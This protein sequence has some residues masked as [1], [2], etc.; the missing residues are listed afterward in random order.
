MEQ[1]RIDQALNTEKISNIRVVQPATLP[2]R[3]SGAGLVILLGLALVL[4][5]LCALGAA[6]ALEYFDDSIDT[7]QRA[8]AQL[9]LPVLAAL[10]ETGDPARVTAPG[11]RTNGA[12]V[13]YSELVGLRDQLWMWSA[14]RRRAF[15]AP[16]ERPSGR[17]PVGFLRLKHGQAPSAP[18]VIALTGCQ[19]GSGVSTLAGH[20]SVLLAQ[21]RHGK[22]LLV[23][24]GDGPGVTQNGAA[25]DSI[26][27]LGAGD[28]ADFEFV[29]V[30]LPAVPDTRATA[31]AAALCDGAILVVSANRTRWQVAAHAKERL[32]E[33]RVNLLG[34]VINRRDFPIPQWLYQTL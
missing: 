3:P 10:P 14:S 2:T 22:V 21:E 20:L 15:S 27:P 33:A 5:A 12:L 23:S 29:V 13:T 17:L 4:A 24:A 30:D 9:R 26:E 8:E 1:A 16:E 18:A 19:A 31:Q 11:P 32:L 34:S 25:T 7:P 6:F 28:G